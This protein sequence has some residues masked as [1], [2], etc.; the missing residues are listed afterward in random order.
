METSQGEHDAAIAAK[1]EE[2]AARK[3]E[4]FSIRKTF[5]SLDN[6][7]KQLRRD[8]QKIDQDLSELTQQESRDVFEREVAE[9][10]EQRATMEAE[11]T[12]KS[13]RMREAQNRI[14][15]FEEDLYGLQ[16]E[17][18]RL[19]RSVTHCREQMNLIRDETD[20]LAVYGSHMPQLLKALERNKARF[21]QPPI[22]PIGR[23]LEVPDM[24]HRAIIDQLVAGSVATFIVNTPKDNEEFFKLFSKEFPR[25][26][27]PSVIQRPFRHTVYDT[28]KLGVRPPPNTTTVLEQL[29]CKNAVVMN[30]LID[31]LRI[32]QC[33]ICETMAVGRK[34][35]E[36]IENVPQNLKRVIVME[37]LCE[38][39]PQPNFRIYSLTPKRTTY[40]QVSAEEKKK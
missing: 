39:F 21:S 22:G 36:N 17:K 13:A 34:M 28:T 35:T 16:E 37:P 26:P 1:K 15:E 33:L 6:K 19:G 11:I 9:L 31:L 10:R 3:D 14:T 32:D 4:F 29:R 20:N 5:Q 8:I 27:K 2:L 18:Q 30:T 7:V 12:E 40:I 23:Y 38:M 25:L 24:R